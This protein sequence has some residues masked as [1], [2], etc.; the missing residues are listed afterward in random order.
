[1]KTMLRPGGQISI[2]D[3]N[4]TALEWQPQPP[5]SMRIFYQAFLKWREDAGMNNRIAED[6][7]DYFVECGFHS[8][9]V[10]KS[11]EV[12]T[13]GKD[14]FLSK[15]GIWSKVAELKQI[16]DEGYL[17]EDTRLRAIA[18]YNEWCETHAERM[19]MKL[20]EVRGRI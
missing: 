7:A 18:E 16:V 6:L 1:M 2:L 14:N 11:D 3:Y 19:T 20:K 15:V 12:Y 13:K 4:H 5:A 9:E 10:H 17:E 8:I